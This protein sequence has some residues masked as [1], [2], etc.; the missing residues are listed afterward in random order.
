MSKLNRIQSEI[1]QLEG[2]RFQKLCDMY[3]YRKRGWDNIVGL[4][5]MDGTDKTTR[6]IPDTYFFDNE[7]S[8]YILVMYGTR[9]DVTAK[10]ETDIREVIGKLK[11]DEKDIK[12][13]ICCHTSSN[14]TVEKD[15]EL[16]NIVNSIELTLIG[17]DTLSQDLLQFKYQDI[18]KDL[19]GISESTEQVWNLEQFILMHDKSKT[20]APLN[21]PYIY[22]NGTIEELIKQINEHQILL[23]YGKPGTGK[24]RLAIEVCKNLPTDSNIICV[25]SNGMPVY[26]EIKDTLDNN[27]V[28]YL[29][30]D[31]AN[32]VTNFTAVVD[33]LKFAEYDQRLKLIITI[34]DYALSSIINQMRDFKI[35]I[36]EVT[37]MS[38][39]QIECLI[40]SIHKVS[41]NNLREIKKL[42]HNN[43]RI[44]VI[45]SIMMRE[46]NNKFIENGKEVLE[47]YY[48]QI[49]KE[50]ALS[51]NEKVSLFILSFKDK[52]NLRKQESL[53][54]VLEFFKID[55]ENFI[56]SIKELHDK[57]LC[58]IFQDEAA[59]V[60]DQSLSDFVI[61]D[62][63]VNNKVF[64][65]RD[66]FISLFPKFEKEILDMFVRINKF[67]SSNDWIDYL[68]NEI[69]YVYNEIIAEID[70][71]RFLKQY[72]ILI[73]IETLAYTNEKMQFARS[74]Q[75]KIS[76]QEF[77]KKKRSTSVEDPIIE[78][79]CSLSHSEKYNDAAVLLI[80][81]LKK[82]PDKVFEIF[83][84]IKSNFDIEDGWNSYLE[85]RYSIFEIFSKQENI[86]K[87]MALLIVNTAEEFLKFSG[88]KI[89]P[90]GRNVLIKRYTLVDGD[91]LI[92]LH[93]KILEMLFEIYKLKYEEVNNYIDKLLF[94]YPIYEVKNGFFKT[95]SSDLKCIED[96]F[97]KDL[98]NLN[99]REEAILFKLNSK[100][101]KFELGS[102]LFS[103]YEASK[104]QVTYKIF[105][106]NPI[107]YKKEGFNYEQSQKLR[108]E[109]LKEFFDENSDDLLQ[110]LNVLS[111]YQLDEL[112]N[113]HEIEKSLS[114][115]YLGLDVDNK[116]KMLMN[117]LISDFNLVYHDFDFYMEKL[118]FEKGRTIL[119]S[120]GK[121]LDERWYLSN[122]L[123]CK[124]INKDRIQELIKYLKE[125]K[126]YEKLNTL[127][128]LA[129]ENYIE[130]DKAILEFLK[131][132]YK[133]GKILGRFFIPN[134]VCEDN[135]KRIINLVGYKELK[136]IY[137][138]IIGNEEI[139]NSGEMFK[140]ILKEQD[141]KFIF[142]F[143][144]KLNALRSN[145]S[146]AKGDVQLEYI[147]ESKV[148]EEGIRKY[149]DFLIQENRVFY[150][151][152][153][154]F[155]EKILKANIERA[156]D[157]IK[158]EVIGTENENRL[159][160][161]YN[162]SLEIFNDEMLINLF[163]LVTD[164]DTDTSFFENLHLTMR[165][166]TWTGS[167]VPLLDKEINFLNNLLDIFRDT[168]YISHALVITTRIDSLKKEKQK[169]LLSDYLE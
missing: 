12:E 100:A 147:W 71:E 131:V 156:F 38:D 139:D 103:E 92:E 141:I 74:K 65:V 88:E 23:L 124:S 114:I 26:Q 137:L 72:G 79:L 153:D 7:T 86:N 167:L 87:T 22:E 3:L 157:F 19:L 83:L 158:N 95:V 154:S 75:C 54:E 40:N 132:K 31:D 17:I 43:P 24:T 44:A 9:I 152:V 125:L 85:K 81:Y 112:L 78:I 84:A 151:G 149:L 13:I 90:N 63:I 42:S 97:Y 134:Y 111:K 10:L 58:D 77:E 46:S 60:S 143:L 136:Q 48:D 18:V 33:L 49:I 32:I 29:F 105:S 21:T 102:H 34:R 68:T 168:K 148:A 98:S 155:L 70:K 101:K 76:Q 4:G 14:L 64:R 118:P 110:W 150:V 47:S 82:R 145:L 30:V 67:E 16:R 133:E 2:G 94:N 166:R 57:E 99:I 130:K 142:L 50:N 73:P 108:A 140:N 165:N 146:F 116:S 8:R 121:A 28:N 66:F 96:L 104:R 163:E 61:I 109:K 127:N 115:L 80:E 162:L 89:I 59:K 106:F 37:L 138:N 20:N 6:G 55:F 36:K 160:S 144:E 164:K 11:V 129:F 69:K 56:F 93:R 51:K 52:L 107:D 161:L 159:V 135:A 122:L 35:K 120:I 62:F 169:E 39:K 119:N 126:N 45:A 1:K 15:K 53:E 113:Q 41:D 5:S 123:T 25:K 128:V 91:Y 27:S 117:L